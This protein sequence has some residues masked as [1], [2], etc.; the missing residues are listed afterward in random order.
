MTSATYGF[1]GE[2]TGLSLADV[3]Q[4]K[5]QNRYLGCISVKYQ[6]NN[7]NIYFE[8]GEIVHAVQSDQVGEEALYTILSWPGGNFSILPDIKTDT[9]TISNNLNFLLLEAHRRMDENIHAIQMRP[10]QDLQPTNITDTPPT[11]MRM[12]SL[13]AAKVM[14]LDGVIYSVLSD[15]QDG[16]P[17]QDNSDEANT[18]V[19]HGL[20][21][22]QA[23]TKLGDY[24]GLGNLKYLILQNKQFG[25]MQ[26][27]GTSHYL[28]IVLDKE[29][30]L[31]DF[32]TKLWSVFSHR[33]KPDVEGLLHQITATDGVLVSAFHNNLGE[34]VA[35]ASCKTITGKQLAKAATEL[36]EDL[37]S[38]QLAEDLLGLELAFTGGRFLI[39]RLSNA[40]ISLLCHNNINKPILNMALDLVRPKLQQA[41]LY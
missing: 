25:F 22:T 41:L 3:I 34:T 21:L 38:I 1:Q 10:D 6:N 30:H 18:V 14:A 26:I 5:G 28:S 2:I 15:K 23:S 13:A 24:L 17:T 40:Y 37:H 11:N 7:G 12:V 39:R 36:I 27:S 32:K 20:Q 31:E 9:C 8:N 29:Q 4:I 19:L 16:L 35:T 33:S